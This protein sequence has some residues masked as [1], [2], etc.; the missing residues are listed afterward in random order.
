MLPQLIVVLLDYLFL[1]LA[2]NLLAVRRLSSPDHLEDVLALFLIEVGGN[3]A[4]FVFG[5]EDSI[6]SL[7]QHGQCSTLSLI[8]LE[9]QHPQGL[10]VVHLVECFDEVVELWREEVVAVFVFVA[11]EEQDHQGL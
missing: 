6:F 7:G 1:L 5:V 8:F 11:E 4:S 2:L 9:G 3:F 10:S